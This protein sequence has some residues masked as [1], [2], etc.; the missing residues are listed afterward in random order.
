MPSSINRATR[1]S[2]ETKRLS[3]K[4]PH[5]RSRSTPFS[6]SSI[7]TKPG[8]IPA[9][10]GLSR[11]RRAQKAWIVP[12]K[13]ESVPTKACD[14][15]ARGP[16]SRSASTALSR[17]FWKR[18]RR[19]AAARIVNVTAEIRS[20]VAR[21]VATRATMRST[22]LLVLPVPAAASTRRVESRF[23]RIALRAASSPRRIATTR[24]VGLFDMEVPKGGEHRVGGVGELLVRALG[25]PADAAA[26][27]FEVAVLAVI[28]GQSVRE[29][30]R[31]QQVEESTEDFSRLLSVEASQEALAFPLPAGKD[32]AGA[33]DSPAT[34]RAREQGLEREGIERGLNMPAPLQTPSLPH[35]PGAAGL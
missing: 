20:T 23:A 31:G 21:P 3:V 11:S 35:S 22:R 5:A 7:S 33:R 34:A 24:S 6:G 27:A 13:Q 30:T 32:I 12:M 15:R 25:R 1:G 29:H 26:D 10:T 17:A 18:C 2:P 8:S 4:R 9:S 16:D 14:R 28:L 19:E